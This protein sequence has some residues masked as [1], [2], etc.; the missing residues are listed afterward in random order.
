MRC[1]QYIMGYAFDYHAQW[2]CVFI[3][4]TLHN[5]IYDLKVLFFRHSTKRLSRI[6]PSTSRVSCP[7]IIIIPL[8]FFCTNGGVPAT[9]FQLGGVS[10]TPVQTDGI[11]A[12]PMQKSGVSATPVQPCGVSALIH[13]IVVIDLS[14]RK[15]TFSSSVLKECSTYLPWDQLYVQSKQLYTPIQT[16]PYFIPVWVW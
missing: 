1:H 13:T 15:S 8:C 16:I 10:N 14:L 3:K 7:N 2:G 6:K 5:W 4:N 12:T 9:I 11:S